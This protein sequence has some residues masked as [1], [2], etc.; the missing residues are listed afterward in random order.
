MVN[1]LSCFVIHTSLLV[2]LVELLL[3]CPI[4]QPDVIHLS[5]VIHPKLRSP[6]I[7]LDFLRLDVTKQVYPSLNTC[8]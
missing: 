2:D 4:L 6:K 8:C 3:W 5:Q 1:S 7:S